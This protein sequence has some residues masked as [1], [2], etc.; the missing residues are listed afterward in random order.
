MSLV[1]PVQRGP[2]TATAA[3]DLPGNVEP[4]V[5][6]MTTSYVAHDTQ[7][8]KAIKAAKAAK[9]ARIHRR[10]QLSRKV[11]KV[12]SV[13]LAVI[14][15]G[16]L[17]FIVGSVLRHPIA[18]TTSTAPVIAA[19]VVEKPA[20]PAAP[21][22]K[23]EAPK[24]P[25]VAVVV[26]APVVPAPPVA[27]RAVAGRF[28]LS[29]DKHAITITDDGGKDITLGIAHPIIT[30]DHQ[31][32]ELDA[33]KSELVVNVLYAGTEATLIEQETP[34]PPPVVASSA[35]APAPVVAQAGNGD[36]P[37]KKNKKKKQTPPPAA[38]ATPPPAN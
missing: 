4:T 2:S 17:I 9:A 32:V 13:V 19:V 15:T 22:V 18:G 5:T 12:V 31:A 34:P 33:L 11:V 37:K 16:I 25:V 23:V 14:T 7:A 36:K 27:P 28:V 21:V 35:A 26:S 10:E 20:P 30:F 8:A 24:E 1:R 29:S 3:T 38:A 6:P